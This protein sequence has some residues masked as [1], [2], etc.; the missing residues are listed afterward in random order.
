MSGR[1]IDGETGKP[2]PNITYGITQ[3]YDGGSSSTSG[4]RSNADGEFTFENLLPGKYSV[5]V[6]PEPNSE[7]RANPVPFEVT[8]H[9]ITGLVI[10]TVKGATLSGVVV[11]EGMR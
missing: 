11:I 9:D 1:I 4:A 8:D 2:L 3:H 7:I 5:Y 10:K 6:E